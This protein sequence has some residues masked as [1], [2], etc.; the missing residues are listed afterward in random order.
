MS[1]LLCIGSP[2]SSSEVLSSTKF[3]LN[4]CSQSGNACDKSLCTSFDSP[5]LFWFSASVDSCTGSPCSS[6]LVLPLLSATGFSVYL[7]T[8]NT[9]SCDEDDDE[10]GSCPTSGKRLDDCSSQGIT[11]TPFCFR[12][13]TKPRLSPSSFSI[14]LPTSHPGWT[15]SSR[16]RSAILPDPCPS[17]VR[18]QRSFFSCF[19]R[20]P[21]LRFS[22]YLHPS[23][24]T[25]NRNERL[26]GSI[27]TSG[28][29]VVGH[30]DLAAPVSNSTWRDKAIRSSELSIALVN[31][32]QREQVHILITVVFVEKTCIQTGSGTHRACSFSSGRFSPAC[33]GI[34]FHT[35]VPTSLVGLNR[36]LPQDSWEVSALVLV[37]AGL[38][39]VEALLRFHWL[40]TFALAFTL[41]AA[42]ALT[43]RRQVHGIR[44]SRRDR[45]LASQIVRRQAW[46]L[47]VPSAERAHR[48][49]GTFVEQQALM[50]SDSLSPDCSS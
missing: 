47:Q 26:S 49:A 32:G 33:L 23:W 31:H 30:T 22:E 25:W 42:F 41:L 10:V 37:V 50:F 43:E 48:H 40:V 45:F 9:E 6:S 18:Q 44:T 34:H 38:P 19:S 13:S 17:P 29:N 8:S 5:F 3:S 39:A 46:W 20:Q 1:A 11:Y 28:L 16:D 35:G 7:L 27:G 36:L 24:G 14:F 12:S 4:S 21:F 2:R 15:P